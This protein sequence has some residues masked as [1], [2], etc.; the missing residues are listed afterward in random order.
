M[1]KDQTITNANTSCKHLITAFDLKLRVLI[2]VS[3]KEYLNQ[4]CF[5]CIS[6]LFERKCGADLS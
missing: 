3:F 6:H 2:M 5:D 1:F 4:L